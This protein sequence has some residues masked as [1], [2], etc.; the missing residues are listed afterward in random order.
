MKKKKLI[1]FSGIDGSGKTTQAKLLVKS[2]QKDGSIA[3][4]VWSRWEPFLLKPLID[5]WKKSKLGNINNTDS[6]SLKIKCEKQKLLLNPVLRLMWLTSF[7]IDYSIQ[8]FFKIRIKLFRK[9][10]IISDRVFYDS[11]IDQ[12]INLGKK[13]EWLINSL[14]SFWMRILF[15]KPDLVLYIDCPEDV[16]FS[17]KNDAPDIEYLIE[18]REL[19][20]MLAD[21]YNWMKIDGT[22]PIN[23]IALQVKDKVYE[24]LGI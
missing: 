2:L 22:F 24:N 23:E 21:K 14:D 16:A 9:Q 5:R 8:I 19:Y 17:R 1:V 12:A 4:Y 20:K 18:R 6:N 15:P 7:Y 13:Q 3:S 10:Y 11:I